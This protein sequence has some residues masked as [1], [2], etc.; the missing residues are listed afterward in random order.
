MALLNG[1]EAAVPQAVPHG[2]TSGTRL[3]RR[4]D[5]VTPSERQ[6]RGASSDANPTGA[7]R[8]SPSAYSTD[9]SSQGGPLVDAAFAASLLGATVGGLLEYAALV[10]GYRTLLIVVAATYGLAFFFGWSYLLESEDS[11]TG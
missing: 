10:F 6:R 4:L 11:V 3:A 5:H 2:D 7:G 8:A 9:G 1:R